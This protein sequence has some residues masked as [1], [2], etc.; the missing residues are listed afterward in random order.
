MQIYQAS[1]PVFQRYLGQLVVLV[2]R[3]ESHAKTQGLDPAALLA[4]R[5]AGD[6]LPFA[7]Q[8]EIAV[9]FALRTCFPLAGEPVPNYG[10]FANSFAGLRERIERCQSLLAGLRPEQFEA[11]EQRLIDSQA[12]QAV[13]RLPAGEFLLQYALPNF[14]FHVTTAYAILRHHRVALGKEDFDG[15]HAYG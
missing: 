6:M 9:N 10:E 12:G 13:L 4:A 5:L 7:V 14:F 8:A 11:A 1:V 2:Q 15:Y 3:A